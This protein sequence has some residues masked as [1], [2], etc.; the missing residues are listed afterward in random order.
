MTIPAACSKGNPNGRG[1]D[2]V[3]FSFLLSGRRP[4][5]YGVYGVYGVDV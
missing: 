2:W 3:M 4:T 1:A 5:A